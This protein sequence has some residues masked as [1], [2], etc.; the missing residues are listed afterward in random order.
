MGG[1]ATPFTHF[2]VIGY[3]FI[4]MVQILSMVADEKESPIMVRNSEAHISF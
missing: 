4:I 1:R 3:F 2:V